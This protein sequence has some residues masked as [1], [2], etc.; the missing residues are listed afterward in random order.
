MKTIITSAIVTLCL[1]STALTPVARA[2]TALTQTALANPLAVTFAQDHSDIQPDPA[3]RFGRLPNGMTY[4]IYR[5]AT[6][7]GTL[8]VHLRIAAGSLME[9]DQ[10]RGLAHFIE[11]MAFNG[12]THIKTDDLI[13]MLQRHGIKLGPDAEAYTLPNK[14][15]FMLD[16]PKNDADSVDT[17]LFVLR[18]FAGNL[19]FEPAAVERERA[20]V[21]GEERLRETP[22]TITQTHW[23]E[24][25]FPGQKFATRGNPIGL[26]D[27]IRTATPDTLRGYYN[28]FYRP[29]LAT[30]VVVGDIDPD[31][32]EA[33][34]KAKFG[35]WTASGTARPVDFGAYRTKGETTFVETAKSLPDTL[36]VTWFRPFDPAAETHRIE[37]DNITD[38]LLLSALNVRLQHQAQQPDCAFATASVGQQSIYQTAKIFQ[39]SVVP[40]PGQDKAAMAQALAMVHQFSAKGVPIDEVAP[41]LAGLDTFFANNDAG[42][43]TRN[44]S[45][46]AQS[47]V[48]NIDGNEVFTS[49]AQD[50]ADYHRFKAALTQ[51]KLDARLKALALADGPLLSHTA[52]D[53]AGLDAP[54]LQAV[55]TSA[56][57][58]QTSAYAAE[59]TKA[60]PYT[61]FGPAQKPVSEKADAAFGDTQYVF[62]NGVR[63]NVLPT[64]LKDNQIMVRVGFAGGFKTIAPTTTAPIT[65][66]GIY[67]GLG[68]Y[69]GGALGKLDVQAL[70]KTLAGKA[71]GISYGLAGDRASLAGETTPADLATEMQLL[72]AYTTDAAYR[73]AV[74]NQVHGILPAIY[75]QLGGSPQ[76]VL[77]THI[78][79]L[80]HVNDN[81]YVFPT[82]DQAQAVTLDQI[83]A[84]IQ[85]SIQNR[86]VEITIVGDIDPKA[87]VAEV[88]ATFGTL[89][90]LT[91]PVPA[92]GGDTVVFPT[93]DLDQTLY[94]KGR[95]DQSIS[96]LSWPV[97]DAAS[98]AKRSRGLQ[99]LAEII[100]ER[101]FATV[102]EKLGQA[103][104]ANASVAQSFDFKN[105]GFLQ[106]SGSVA[107]GQDLA[108]TQAVAAIIDDLKA[109][110]VSQ[111]ELDRARKP[112][113][114]RAQT[115][116]KDNGYWLNAIATT[117]GDAR[118]V[119]YFTGED[120]DLAA[121]TPAMIQDLAKTYL[122]PGK[123]LHIKVVPEAATNPPAAAK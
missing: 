4:V 105:Y 102:R 108:F 56:M 47:I 17:A 123:A 69:F 29:E 27:I 79:S 13:P 83:K 74:F 65:F 82:L 100:N 76:G 16:L 40:K 70:Q 106:V 62:A 28:A 75:T 91:P 111:D 86:P 21:L 71:V 25:A 87:A 72:M 92:A 14:T 110:P 116:R 109:H 63:L 107:T 96:L 7:S 80:T 112:V 2:Q 51:D 53:L 36:S 45:S 24:A 59:A 52:E 5:N 6:P 60:W 23:L 57:A 122:V 11:H 67:A 41:V 20:V 32:I 1:A 10:E 26:P 73:P 22:A 90:G 46:I 8:S 68:G 9:S 61:D 93:H 30:L 88:G 18:E 38:A 85:T 89:A 31:A 49:P 97:P 117:E 95:A 120:A 55:Y 101:A 104:D 81:R 3:A 77:Q 43:K 35:D 50:L 42:A 12:T 78:E 98:D 34:I 113:V 103:Y 66:T 44:T 19:T 48:S 119:A 94:H 54:A 39:L 84:V 58:G 33:K 99:I 115:S 64:K 15:E 118:R 37:D 114:D 121:V